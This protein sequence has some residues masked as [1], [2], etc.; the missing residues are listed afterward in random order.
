[1][2]LKERIDVD[3]NNVYNITNIVSLLYDNEE[4]CFYI[5]SNK[6]GESIGIFLTKFYALTP[7]KFR[8][9]TMWR[10]LLQVGDAYMAISKGIDSHGSWYKELIVG[11]KTIFI[12]TYTII[13]I[14][15][16]KHV[17]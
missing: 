16:S 4:D 12:N 3:I 6:E 17:E 11:F 13:V 8:F 15:L 14:E 9:I 10:H 7:G 2:S 5:L 1:V